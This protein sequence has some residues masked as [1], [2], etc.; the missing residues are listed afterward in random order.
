MAAGRRSRPRRTASTC[1]PSGAR[2]SSASTSQ[3]DAIMTTVI[4]AGI[5]GNTTT[6]MLARLQRDVL[7]HRPDLVVLM[8]G[9]NDCCNSAKLADP[10]VVAANYVALADAILPHARLLLATP[11]ANHQPYL[12]TR[13]P[14]EAYAG[15]PAAER[16]R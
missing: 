2:W 12:D 13:H 1:R 14:R 5:G 6:E 9:T 7:A 8:A 16:M 3:S 10:A 15:L 4:N 11:P